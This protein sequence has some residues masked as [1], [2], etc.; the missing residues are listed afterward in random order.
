MIPIQ[1]IKF[2]LVCIFF[3]VLLVFH[4]AWVVRSWLLDPYQPMLE[5]S[6]RFASFFADMILVGY[7]LCKIY[8]MI[9]DTEK[10]KT[11]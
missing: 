2:G 6:L 4:Y 10:E 7:L 9:Y 8:P 5:I 3:I 11:N 1:D